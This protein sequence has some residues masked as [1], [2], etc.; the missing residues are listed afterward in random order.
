MLVAALLIVGVVV[1]AVHLRHTA[2][3]A[4]DR[5]VRT[6]APTAPSRAGAAG[7]TG[8]PES[9]ARTLPPES[10]TSQTTLA[11]LRARHAARA[12]AIARAQASHQ[13][14]QPS[15]NLL[16]NG[17]LRPGS[18]PNPAPGPSKEEQHRFLSAMADSKSQPT[19]SLASR[20]RVQAQLNARVQRRNKPR[21][22]NDHREVAQESRA[23]HVR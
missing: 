14:H 18:V 21:E 1:W 15:P 17:D 20:D 22:A 3:A 11:E 9:P 8:A 10:Y 16:P 13:T 23:H 6:R 5:S 4:D 12:T 2:S 7:A 19:T